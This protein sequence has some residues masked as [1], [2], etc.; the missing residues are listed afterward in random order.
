[1]LVIC[2]RHASERPVAIFDKA[3]RHFDGQLGQFLKSVGVLPA[4]G[5][6][7]LL[8]DSSFARHNRRNIPEDRDVATIDNVV[9]GDRQSLTA[10]RIAP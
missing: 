6:G 2:R 10:N 4:S 1:V 8:G 7:V 5:R 3:A 9:A